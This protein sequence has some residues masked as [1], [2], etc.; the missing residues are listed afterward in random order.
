M[1]LSVETLRKEALSCA[2]AAHGGIE[3]FWN[4]PVTELFDWG[5]AAARMYKEAEERG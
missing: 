4:L 2:M 5:D 1:P 3:F